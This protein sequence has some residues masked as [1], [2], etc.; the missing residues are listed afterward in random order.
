M[1]VHELDHHLLRR[2]NSAWAKYAEAFRTIAFV[3]F[4]SRTSRSSAFAV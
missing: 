1:V 3:R 2:S 4:S